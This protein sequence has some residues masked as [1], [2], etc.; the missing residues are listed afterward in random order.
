MALAVSDTSYFVASGEPPGNLETK[1]RLL[2]AFQV[3]RRSVAGLAARR[4]RAA[5]RRTLLVRGSHLKS[6]IQLK[7][8]FVK[9]DRK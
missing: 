7:N 5:S 3:R 8:A 9:S 4:H 2:L 1:L 6:S